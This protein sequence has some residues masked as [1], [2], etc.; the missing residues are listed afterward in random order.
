MEPKIWGPPFWFIIHTIAFYY[1]EK[2]SFNEKRHMFEFFQNLQYIIPCQVCRQHYTKH[3]QEFPVTPFLDNKANLVSWT[4]QLHNRVN[5]STG[6]PVK[7]VEEVIRHY[8]KVYSGNTFS[9]HAIKDP[10]DQ[11]EW[12]DFASIKNSKFYWNLLFVILIG[13]IGY[14]YLYRFKRAY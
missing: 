10:K 4:V 3:F 12:D 5:E 14:F 7:S 2:P 13:L 6:K 8:Q 1:P 9:C 11:N